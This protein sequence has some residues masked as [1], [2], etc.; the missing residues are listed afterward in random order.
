MKT[1]DIVLLL[2]LLWGAYN[3]YR[4]GLLMSFVA[5]AA[6]VIAVVVGFRLLHAGLEWISPHLTGVPRRLLPYIG[7]SALFFPIIFIVTKLGQV[8]RNSWK[9]T[10]IG[11]FD[12]IAGAIVG[13]MLWAFGASVVIWLILA[14]GIRIPADARENSIV[15]PVV[16]PMAPLVIDKASGLLPAGENLMQKL[17][18]KI[19]EA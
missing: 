5:I 17:K 13:L 10:L 1:V 2:P 15:Y 14:L 6:F 8:L 4:K 18:K 9:Y 3:G 19:Q 7:F 16:A 12:S 11:S